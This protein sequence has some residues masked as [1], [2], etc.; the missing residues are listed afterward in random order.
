M[1]GSNRDNFSSKTIKAL[2]LRAN[3]RCSFP[4]CG[5]STSGPSNE[6]PMAHVNIG[7]A[8][9]IHG[10][11]P[12][13]R[14][15]L[16]S[17]TPEQRS[18]IENGIWLCANHSIEI[19]RDEMRYTADV[20]RKMKLAHEIQVS[21]ELSG[22]RPRMDTDFIAL[23]QDLI[24]TGE[25]IGTVEYEWQLRIDHF[26]IGDLFKLI[27][28]IERFDH[29]DKYD[30]YVLVNAFG[31]GRQLAAA[32]VWLKTDA[33][34]IVSCRVLKSFPRTSA[35]NIPTDTAL[36]DAHDIFLVNGDFATVSGLAALPQKIKVCLSTFRGEMQSDP[37]FGTRIKEYFDLFQDSPWL[38]RLIKLEVIRL[39]C[40]PYYDQITKQDCTPLQS[41][42][43]VYSIEQLPSE[44]KANWLPFRFLLEV[45]GVGSW[46]HDIPIFVPTG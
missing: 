22:S 11:A 16:P 46:Q 14:R 27:K 4:G 24:F 28:F 17:M 41:V 35:H 36:S 33:G 7:V 38:L 20:L 9:H 29:I 23:G 42:L 26:L 21:S 43:R 13:S 44:Q 40:V 31:D 32:P 1:A 39:A 8:A 5:S 18:H 34:Y 25:V 10:A 30:R 19:D 6:S 45:D 3:H 12:G 15:Y 37:I 2:G